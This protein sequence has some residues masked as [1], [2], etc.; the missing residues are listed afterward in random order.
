MK[1]I[2]DKKPRKVYLQW[3][4]ASEFK[5]LPFDPHADPQIA[6]LAQNALIAARE[7][8]KSLEYVHFLISDRHRDRVTMHIDYWN[9][10][11]DDKYADE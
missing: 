3:F 2:L 4:T 5:E 6:K 7:T 11:W 8:F 9:G 1:S 10:D